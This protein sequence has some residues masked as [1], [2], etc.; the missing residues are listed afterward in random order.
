[1]KTYSPREIRQALS[2]KGF[3]EHSGHH[4]FLTLYV[5]GRK[6]SIRTRVSHGGKDYGHNLMTRL[7][8]QLRLNG[9]AE[10]Q[11]LLD[12]PMSRDKYVDLMVERGHVRLAPG[13]ADKS[14]PK[15]ENT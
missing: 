4:Q 13:P 5:D 2:R 11:G 14:L 9:T 15:E 7:K 1:V 3:I 6:T 12:C 8:Q 10:L